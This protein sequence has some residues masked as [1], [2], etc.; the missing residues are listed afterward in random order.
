MCLKQ[1][2][3]R[4]KHALHLVDDYFAW[5]AKSGGDT[6]G[7]VVDVFMVDEDGTL[8]T[9][10]KETIPLKTELIY[11]D[12]IAAPRHVMSSRKIPD[13]GVKGRSSLGDIAQSNILA[14]YKELTENPI[15]GPTRPVQ[16]ICFRIEEVSF[17]H[18][19]HSGFKIRVSL[20]NT[21]QMI[22]RPAVLQETLVVLSKPKIRLPPRICRESGVRFDR[23]QKVTDQNCKLS[24]LIRPDKRSKISIVEDRLSASKKEC[25]FFQR[26]EGLGSLNLTASQVSYRSELNLKLVEKITTTDRFENYHNL[27]RPERA[28]NLAKKKQETSWV[29][30]TSIFASNEKT[31][32]RHHSDY[33]CKSIFSP[34]RPLYHGERDSSI[35]SQISGL[36]SLM[37]NFDSKMYCIPAYNF[38]QS[39]L[40]DLSFRH[41]M[42][43]VVSNE[44]TETKIFRM[45]APQTAQVSRTT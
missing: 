26:S 23:N 35:T 31:L 41:A 36:S 17:Y 40:P 16:T 43:P 13:K 3:L 39:L 30:K 2:F 29:V 10:H 15:L 4:N 33:S 6:S 24:S 27:G 32:I 42:V 34:L 28:E 7:L 20:V 22:V 25:K 14:L 45:G 19:S 18:S 21:A 12:G 9:N 5:F 37:E 38:D 11:S 1:H 8:V 44:L